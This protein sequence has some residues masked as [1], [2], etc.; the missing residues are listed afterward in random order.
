MAPPL[1]KNKPVPIAPPM[2]IMLN[3]R[4]PML[5]WSP[6]C[7]FDVAAR[8]DVAARFD[9]MPRAW[10]TVAG[11]APT[12]STRF[13]DRQLALGA[14]GNGFGQLGLGGPLGSDPPVQPGRWQVV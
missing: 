13:V 4:V 10:H 6:Q 9:V 11:C 3:C 12:A 1:A 5:R 7:S 2:A 8:V 14:T